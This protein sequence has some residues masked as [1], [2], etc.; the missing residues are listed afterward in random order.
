MTE[1]D[2]AALLDLALLH[3]EGKLTEA[4]YDAAVKLMEEP[5]PPVPARLSLDEGGEGLPA[6]AHAI[7]ARVEAIAGKAFPPTS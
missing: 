1:H 4:Q 7:R 3:K 5:E 6:I 2:Q